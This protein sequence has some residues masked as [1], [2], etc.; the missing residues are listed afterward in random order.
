MATTSHQCEHNTS[1]NA[2]EQTRFE[3]HKCKKILQ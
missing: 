2:V 3:H 1:S